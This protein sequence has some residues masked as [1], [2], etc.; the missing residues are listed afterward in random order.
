L[1]Y[2]EAWFRA[3]VSGEGIDLVLKESARG[4]AAGVWYWIWHARGKADQ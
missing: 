1:H 2:A 4:S 3:L